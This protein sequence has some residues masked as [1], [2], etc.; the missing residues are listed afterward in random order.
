MRKRRVERKLALEVLFTLELNPQPVEEILKNRKLARR[1][2]PSDFGMK[3]IRGV[4]EHKKDLDKLIDKYAE[5]WRVERM[6]L[7]DRNILRLALYE[8][9]YENQ[10]PYGVSINEAVELAK[11][12]GTEDSGRFVNG[13]L[14]KVV[15][16]E[17]A[18]TEAD[19]D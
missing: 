2:L 4:L 17:F 8:I 11:L 19:E 3:L 18:C 6:P 12:Y 13:V 16:E 15:R 10:I 14:G 9:I 5:N 7:T 1:S